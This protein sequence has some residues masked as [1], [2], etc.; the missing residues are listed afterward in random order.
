MKMVKLLILLFLLFLIEIVHYTRCNIIK[1]EVIDISSPVS[2]VITSCDRT[3][4]L[5]NL[6]QSMF[7]YN[8]YKLNKKIG[9]CK[10]IKPTMT[11]QY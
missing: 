5:K 6:L 2:L 1:E 4:F 10:I 11:E 8:K 9:F 3:E 7:T